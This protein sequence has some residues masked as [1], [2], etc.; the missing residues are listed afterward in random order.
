MD[1]D[2]L[3]PW[4]PGCPYRLRALGWVLDRYVAGGWHPIV[5]TCPPGPWCK[6]LA[7]AEALQSS[8]AEV[9]VV[10]DADVWCTELQRAVDLVAGG[11]PWAMP[12]RD[13]VRF[14]EQATR[15][16]IAGTDPAAL[17]AERTHLE[18][19]HEGAWGGGLVVLDR[20]TYDQVPLDVRFVGWGQEDKSWA[21]ALSVLAGRPARLTGELWHLW[22][23]PQ[24]RQSRRV[25]SRQGEALREKYQAR[26]GRP[27]R[28]AA[29]VD[30]GRV[31]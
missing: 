29:L 27:A 7:V 3:I 18:E 25:G 8:D 30:E 12:H 11:T 31:R 4:Q 20:S 19:R 17:T 9:V 14:T 26:R 10:A 23:P 1:V 24:Q 2:V 16:I 13:V 28:L 22:H 5:G 21:V 6:A 15:R